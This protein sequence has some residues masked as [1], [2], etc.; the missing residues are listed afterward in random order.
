MNITI[1]DSNRLLNKI[2]KK[3]NI[4]SKEQKDIIK[5][6]KPIYEHKEFQKRM[7]DK[8]PHHGNFTLGFHI[9]EDTIL[10]YVLS[11]R[12]LKKHPN[13]GYSLEL[14]L[15]IS[16]L[17]DL[18][19]NPWQNNPSKKKL[20]CNKHGFRHS[21]ESI[22]NACV[23]FPFIFEKEDD[24][25]IIIDGVLHH[26]FPLPVRCFT[27]D[28]DKMELNN[29]SLIDKIPSNILDLIIKSSN[30]HKIGNYSLCKSKY[31]EGRIM[32]RADKL[33][34]TNEIKNLSSLSAL[35][36]GHHNSL[37]KGNKKV[38]NNIKRK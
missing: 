26:M 28:I 16:M 31:K 27:K 20:F 36:S 10:T 25:K 5:I 8:Y 34:S 19:T 12:Y 21:L 32:A 35:I 29:S 33:M 11:K 2:F 38:N 17:H 15:K 22:I 6:I 13:S 7:S 1:I 9:L 3:Y 23:W 30:R 4:K 37:I 18:Y 14:A 24:A